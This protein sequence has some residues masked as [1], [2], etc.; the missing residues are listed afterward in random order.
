MKAHARAFIF[1]I[2]LSLFGQISAQNWQYARL[3]TN[4]VG[5]RII[6]SWT[7]PTE[8]V[9]AEAG[10]LVLA[11]R[12]MGQL[13]SDTDDAFIVFMNYLGRQG[14]ELIWVDT[15]GKKKDYLFKRLEP[16]AR[17]TTE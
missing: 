16:S 9:T 13:I 2:C 17:F 1:V 4:I 6:A 8:K 15:N 3:T 5:G 7:S 12:I 14:W 11:E 10:I